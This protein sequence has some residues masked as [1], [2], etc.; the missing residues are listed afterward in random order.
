MLT[1]KLTLRHSA[2]SDIV[3]ASE[4]ALDASKILSDWS[5]DERSTLLER[6][7]FGFAS[8]GRVRFHHRSAVEYLAAMRLEVHLARGVS[9][10]AIKRILFAETAQGTRTVRPSMR[11]G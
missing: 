8:Y 2:E 9:I 4:A 6:P 1:R 10:K 5:A 7:L 3:Q 11:A